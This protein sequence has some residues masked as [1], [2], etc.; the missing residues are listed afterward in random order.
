MKDKPTYNKCLRCNRKLK[1]E[2]AKFRGYGD[3]CWHLHIIEKRQ[4][5]NRLFDFK[6]KEI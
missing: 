5:R 4:K 3:Y 1:T 2:K 6:E